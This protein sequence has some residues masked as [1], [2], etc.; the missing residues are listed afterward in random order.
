MF[1]VVSLSPKPLSIYRSEEVGQS[2]RKEIETAKAE[3]DLCGGISLETLVPK[4]M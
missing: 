1:P 4:L 3:G 2:C